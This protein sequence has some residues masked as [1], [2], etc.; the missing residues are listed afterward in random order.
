MGLSRLR[1]CYPTTLYYLYSAY[2]RLAFAYYLLGLRY[3]Q[4]S[5][6]LYREG[7]REVRVEEVALEE[8]DLQGT[9]LS[10]E[11]VEEIL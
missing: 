7:Y 5:T 4:L 8:R 6:I 3:L 1:Y 9:R 2:W 11:K 10:R